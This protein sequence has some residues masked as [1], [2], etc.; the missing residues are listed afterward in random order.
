MPIF[1]LIVWHM[2]RV[3]H[4]SA[5]ALWTPGYICRAGDEAN[6]C[7]TIYLLVHDLSFACPLPIIVLEYAEVLFIPLLDAQVVVPTLQATI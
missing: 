1:I 7:I 4:S 6:N 2:Y 5:L 3:V